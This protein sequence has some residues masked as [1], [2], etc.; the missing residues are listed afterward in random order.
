MEEVE[1]YNALERLKRTE[2]RLV[3]VLYSGLI[4][5]VAGGEW[6]VV[7]RKR[8]DGRIRWKGA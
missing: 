2:G 5:W 1:D 3:L 7:A 4:Y 6:I 8:R